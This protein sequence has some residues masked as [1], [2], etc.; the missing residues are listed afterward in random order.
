MAESKLLLE[1]DSYS[2]QLDTHLDT[3][4]EKRQS[5]D[6]AWVRLKDIYE[7][8]AAQAF[9]EAFEASSA[10]LSVY[11]ERSRELSRKLLGKIAEL[12]KGETDVQAV[13]ES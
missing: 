6:I 7:G 12:R 8:E 2:K 13:S 9:T 3:L 5:L 4:R 10:R 11:E 1:L